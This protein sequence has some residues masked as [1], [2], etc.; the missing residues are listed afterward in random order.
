MTNTICDE[1][2]FDNQLGWCENQISNEQI[3]EKLEKEKSKGFLAFSWGVF[4]TSIARDN[5]LRRV[6]D[7][8]YYTVY[9]DTDSEKLIPGYNK[10]VIEDYNKSVLETLEK[11]S[12]K[13][14]IPL[15]KFK[16]KD[17]KGYE[18]PL[19]IFELEKEKFNE[20]SYDS[21]ITQRS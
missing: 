16:P 5:L 2:T 18:R 8:D 19:G 6:I 1:V 20:F 15:E 3:I 7:N 4:V 13:L 14:D 10:Q 12:K 11:A 17:K 9:C 21:F